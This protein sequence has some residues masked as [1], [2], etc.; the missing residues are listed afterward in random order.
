MAPEIV[1]ETT[2]NMKS[3]IWAL[4]CL[5]YEMCALRQAYDYCSITII[6]F[7]PPFQAKTQLQLNERIKMGG[8]DRIPSMYSTELFQMIRCMLQVDVS[9][10]QIV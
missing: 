9:E 6:L 8:V 10:T 5:V 1:N 3:D 7:R 2:Y 4:G